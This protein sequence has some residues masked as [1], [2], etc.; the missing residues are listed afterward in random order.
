MMPCTKC[1][2]K[3]TMSVHDVRFCKAEKIPL[4]P[5][6]K[7]GICKRILGQYLCVSPAQCAQIKTGYACVFCGL[8]IIFVV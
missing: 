5:F 7:G 8:F 1:G 2:L 4:T 6:E 3:Q